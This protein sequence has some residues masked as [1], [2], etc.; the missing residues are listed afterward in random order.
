MAISVHRSRVD[1]G[2]EFGPLV[3]GVAYWVSL[4]GMSKRPR[5][6]DDSEDFECSPCGGDAEALGRSSINNECPVCK[7]AVSLGDGVIV[8]TAPGHES[9]TQI[10]VHSKNCYPGFGFFEKTC[11]K[12]GVDVDGFKAKHPQQYVHMVLQIIEDV[13]ILQ[14]A[15]GNL[16]RGKIARQKAETLGHEM[17]KFI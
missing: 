12:L 1:C 9:S 15:A 7:N 2:L 6:P 10:I 14:K 11:R 16:R 4:E 13:H 17:I 8:E 5:T 3:F